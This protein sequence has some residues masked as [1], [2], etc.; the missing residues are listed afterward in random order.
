MKRTIF[1]LFSFIIFYFF[2]PG[3]VAAKSDNSFV[4]IVNPVRG[5]DFW[6]EPSQD[7]T[8]SV[9]GQ[10][11]I[12]KKNDL[13]ATWLLRFDAFKETSLINLIK[14]DASN[15]EKGLFLEVTP[16]WATS[17]G[18]NY[19]QSDS[20][21]LP[22]SV[23]LIGYYP[24]ERKRLI[25][26]AFSKFN[27]VF[28]YYPKSV[29]AWW[30]DSIS[31]NYMQEKYGVTSVLIVADQFSTDHYQVW[32]QYFGTPYYPD[33]TNVLFPSREKDRKL[34]VVMTQWAARDPING[35]GEGVNETTYSVQPN[36]YIDFHDLDINYF[37]KLM[38]IYLDQPLN[39]FNQLT[40]GLENSYS[41]QK[42]QSEYQKQIQEVKDRQSQGK[43]KVLT[44]AD[45][46]SWYQK[47]FPDISPEHIIHAKDPLGSDQQVVWF[48]NPFYRAGWFYNKDGSVFR[49]IR[50]YTN[51]IEPC[52]DNPCKEL[53]LA[54]SDNRILDDVTFKQ[55]LVVDEGEITDIEVS[56]QD[57]PILSY[58]NAAGK[59]RVIKFLG[60]D[61]VFDSRVSSIDGIILGALNPNDHF[62]Y[63]PEDV[64]KLY[65][66]Y[67]E[68]Y[69]SFSEKVGKFLTFILLGLFLPGYASIRY[70]KLESRSSIVFNSL[71][72][73]III[74]T[75]ASYI[76]GYLHIPY[77]NYT[78]MLL[79]L[80][81][82]IY[83]KAYKDISLNSFTPK[84]SLINL[85]TI[86][87][88][89]AGTI[90]QTL[91]LVKS[92]WVY[93]LGVGFWGP[94][95]HDMVWH[96]ALINQ[97][98]SLPPQNPIFSG[99][100]LQNYHY[101]YD[102]IVAITFNLTQIPIPDLI[103]RFYPVIFSILLGIGTYV[104]SLK[105]FNN[106]KAALLSLFFVYFGG[107]LGWV[108][109]Y[110]KYKNLLGGE[111]T[112]W[113]NQAVSM[114]LNPPFMISILLL[115]SFLL[116]FRLFEE[117]KSLSLKIILVFTAGLLI[118]FKVYV[119]VLVLGSLLII[120]LYK[121]IIKRDL[122]LFYIFLPTLL[123]ALLV[124]VPQNLYAG[125]LIL[126]SPLWFIHSM[127]DSSDR[128]GWERLSLARQAYTARG[129][130]FRLAGVEIISVA[131]FII[132]NLGTRILTIFSLPAVIKSKFWHSN[133]FH[134]I[135]WIITLSIVISLLFIQEGNPW[136]TIQFSYYGLYLI[137]LLAAGSILAIFNKL[138]K[139]V[140]F[141][142]ILLIIFITPISSFAT[143]KGYLTETP[144]TVIPLEELDALDQLSKLPQGT[145][146]TYPYSKDLD[147]S[148]VYPFPL[149]MNVTTSYVSA[150]S[151]KPTF[152]EDEIQQEIWQTDYK[153]RLL[154]A[155]DIFNG[156]DLEFS[157]ESIKKY[158]IKYLY[159][160]KAYK[161]RMD[162]ME[163]G[164]DLIFENTLV[165]VFEVKK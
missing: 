8:T 113:I 16:T 155:R 30:V 92:G 121:F 154:V 25:D 89:I 117:N 140:G 164:L 131:I 38:D 64:I 107:S 11:D 132:G 22:E 106:K 26:S 7:V 115:I 40:I 135:F 24:E 126:F 65:K 163:L 61:I 112:F 44:M 151:N 59:K 141:A 137:S 35:Y 148:F 94:T 15:N 82:L 142:F 123:V 48:M 116:L 67:K 19:N 28:G 77:G 87:L 111:S 97:M 138:P 53:N 93:P 157:K 4:T 104:L 73:G 153:K 54:T 118:G 18:V 20:W 120:S 3:L 161:V 144:H 14:Q 23:F 51:K 162:T 41:W 58:M 79:A 70:L 134:I 52:I 109:E 96:Q 68:N 75:L 12:L 86:I 127:I 88:I 108:V 95:S 81:I 31:I 99:E 160:P 125:S 29:G 34:S 80:L 47:E 165:R 76:L 156:F 10:I 133:I 146:L 129:D 6:E 100:V 158:N 27:E 90:F 110:I 9:K 78:V 72:F 98:F 57:T 42:Y 114:N 37:K 130:W 105:L 103:Y 84:L 101:F 150:Y 91:G 50:Q 62:E 136:N 145:T 45:F 1:F 46:S 69:L 128:V 5:K 71:I 32:G 43:L 102:L 147:T 119:G 21:H 60:Q 159:L 149:F 124:F 122:S 17:V 74:Q 13:P 85:I 152:V 2:A 39:K 66:K 56:R 143:F 139:F 33:R 49:D 55:K 36:D 63:K 83:K